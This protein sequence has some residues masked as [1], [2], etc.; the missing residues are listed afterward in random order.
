MRGVPVD[1]LDR[2]SEVAPLFQYDFAPGMQ[3]QTGRFRLS[4]GKGR[5]GNQ[6][7]GTAADEFHAQG[8]R[9]TGIETGDGR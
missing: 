7:I 8:F 3:P 2:G 1:G 9:R 4:H 5:G 6:V